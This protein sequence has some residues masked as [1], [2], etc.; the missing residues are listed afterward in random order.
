MESDERVRKT[1]LVGSDVA[2]D[3]E[4]AETSEH[5]PT[6]LN[7]HQISESLCNV[8]QLVNFDDFLNRPTDSIEWVSTWNQICER[9]WCPL[10]RLVRKSLLPYVSARGI[11]DVN[12]ISLTSYNTW[13]NCIAG[14]QYQFLAKNY[15]AYSNLYDLKHHAKR[16]S[17]ASRCE[18]KADLVNTVSFD[19]GCAGLHIRPLLSG[20]FSARRVDRD[21]ANLEL[22]REWLDICDTHHTGLCIPNAT[23]LMVLPTRFRLID[24]TRNKIVTGIPDIKP[25]YVALTYVWGEDKMHMEMPR[26]LK[27]SVHTRQDGVERIDLPELL[28][29]TISDAIE[30]TRSLGFG[31]L[32]VDSLCIIQDD[33]EDRH[34]QINMMDEIYRNASLTIASGSSPHADWGLPGISIPRL[35]NQ[36]TEKIGPYEFAIAFP[37]FEE[38]DDGTQLM[39]NTRGWTMQEKFLSRRLL[40]FTD[41]QMYFRCGNSSF[42]EDVAMET[43]PLPHSTL[44]KP[45][46]L[47]FD[48]PSR[49]SQLQ[50]PWTGTLLALRRFLHLKED[51]S[52]AY[53]PIYM[54]LLKEYTRRSLTFK[55]DSLDA[56]SGVLRALDSSDL[57]FCAGLPRKWLPQVL[58]W[59]PAWGCNYSIDYDTRAGIP[60]WSWAVW[61]LA[62]GCSLSSSLLFQPRLSESPPMAIYY[63]DSECRLS[64]VLEDWTC[65]TPN[66]LLPQSWPELSVTARA[67]L[68]S[69]GF[70]LGFQTSIEEFGI[71]RENRGHDT[72]LYPE[73]ECYDFCLTDKAGRHVGE[74]STCSRVAGKPGTHQFI[75]LSTKS[76]EFELFED[77]VDPIYRP[78]KKFTYTS[79][80]HTRNREL[81]DETGGEVVVPRHEWKITNVM[82]VEW[83]DDVALK[84]AIGHIISTAFE[85]KPER[86]VYLG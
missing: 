55:G 3:L 53:L 72:T 56:I 8:C 60:S 81:V 22:A 79:R 33:K 35:V 30:V 67:H 26:T 29:R 70:L 43:G 75:A 58:L 38:I 18:F 64:R 1:E 39:W 12:K 40:L 78:K 86:M 2:R 65:K 57:A 50:R 14:N 21:H 36:Q 15:K 24:V 32:W 62:G 25:R 5:L 42:T 66:K 47:H 85:W 13:K 52:L 34:N 37:T 20:P 48:G 31:Y 27:L 7:I 80:F 59:K 16:T 68:D 61:S 23:S 71:G 69:S 6:N 76:N 63:K 28:P 45:N 49:G 46:P 41:M 83:R 74:V 10:C 84:V 82:L 54:H 17:T 51:S 9:I 44:R 19:G 11:P 73:D 4:C 77:T